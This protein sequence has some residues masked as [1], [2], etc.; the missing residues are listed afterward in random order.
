MKKF[1]VKHLYWIIPSLIIAIVLL[2]LEC[3]PNGV[4]MKFKWPIDENSTVFASE[5]KY[6]P[7]FSDMPYGYGNF[8]PVYIGI[9]TIAVIILCIT[10]I[11]VDKK[12]IDIAIVVLNALKLIGSAVELFF[13]RT[14]INWAIFALSIVFTVYSSVE[15]AFR[16]KF[17]KSTS[18]TTDTPI[19]V[20]ED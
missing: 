10:N 15:L 4:E 9:L 7:Y 3:L 18:S 13:S 16:I 5:T 8:V 2:V 19:D 17:E 20:Q 12:G 1:N 6:Y 11:F 14:A